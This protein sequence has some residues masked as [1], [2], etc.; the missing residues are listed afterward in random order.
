MPD[1]GSLALSLT[2]DATNFE[3]GILKSL[4]LAKDMG[5]GIDQFGQQFTK[6]MTAIEADP[7]VAVFV[8]A[9]WAAEK[10]YQVSKFTTSTLSDLNA[11]GTKA[12]ESQSS[13]SRRLGLSADEAAGL[14]LQTKKLGLDSGEVSQAMVAFQVNLS[15]AASGSVEAA[16]GFKK[17]G[18]DAKELSHLS[19][20]DQLAAVGDALNGIANKGDRTATMYEVLTR[21]GRVLTE[22]VQ[23]GTKGQQDAIAMS[24]KLGLTFSAADQAASR[25][26]QLAEKDAQLAVNSIRQSFANGIASAFFPIRQA[27]AESTSGLVDFVQPVLGF[28]RGG[29]LTV[30]GWIQNVVTG[31]RK[32]FE[33]YGAPLAE[34]KARLTEAWSQLSTALGLTGDWRETMRAVGH[35]IGNVVVANLFAAAAAVTFVAGALKAIIPIVQEVAGWI[36]QKIQ[37]KLD[38]LADRIAP[39][40]FAWSVARQVAGAFWDWLTGIFGSSAQETTGEWSPVFQWFADAW[41]F[42]TKPIFAVAETIRDT[43][44]GAIEWVRGTFMRLVEAL[45]ALPGKAGAVFRQARAEMEKV[46]DAI[47]HPFAGLDSLKFDVPQAALADAAQQHD[48]DSDKKHKEEGPKALAAGSQ[49]ALETINRSQGADDPNRILIQE[50]RAGNAILSAIRQALDRA[51]NRPGQ[52]PQVVAL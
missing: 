3:K 31:I 34:I 22:I 12:A 42:M 11:E 10:L 19:A 29:I 36:G 17:L 24:E 18:L 51:N 30:G 39:F 41:S 23:Q 5:K 35:W 38:G 45:G 28:L 16:A 2:V 47:S 9:A 40:I 52:I 8:A 25:S 43:L 32:S 1:I 21:R 4:N 13:L 27:F 6:V 44:G 20:A 7:L 46:K 15:K 49:A 33:D 37:A 50:T 26:A 48:L 14:S